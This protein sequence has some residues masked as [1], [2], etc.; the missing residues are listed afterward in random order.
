MQAKSFPNLG[1]NGLQKSAEINFV[2]ISYTDTVF[3]ATDFPWK[4]AL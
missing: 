3:L 2:Q 1:R 4:I